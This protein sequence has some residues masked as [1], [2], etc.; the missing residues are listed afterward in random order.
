MSALDQMGIEHAMLALDGTKI[1]DVGL[2]SIGKLTHLIELTLEETGITGAGFKHLA[3]LQD[4]RILKFAETAVTDEAADVLKGMRKLQII[5]AT[6]VKGITDKTIELVKDLPNIHTMEL[7]GTSVT[8][9]TVAML[10]ELKRMHCYD[11]AQ[12]QVTEKGLESLKNYSNAQSLAIDGAQATE[13]GLQFVKDG[14]PLFQEIYL[15]GPEINDEFMTRAKTTLNGLQELN[16]F[17]TALTDAGLKQLAEVQSL[18]TV[19]I[20]QEGLTP[21]GIDAFRQALPNVTIAAVGE[22]GWE[23]I[24]P[25]GGA[26]AITPMP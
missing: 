3:G 9:A 6:N 2:E 13:K 8:D 16:L 24:K 11:L 20:A 4:I 18:T 23:F 10:S 22:A 25:W 12:S 17:G 7:R 1:T 15:Y 26:V 19:R 5:G 14:L 21:E